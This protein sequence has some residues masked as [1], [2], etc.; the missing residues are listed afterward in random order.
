ML[1]YIDDCLLT[2]NREIEYK[3]LEAPLADKVIVEVKEIPCYRTEIEVLRPNSGL[4]EERLL[5][6]GTE[7][8]LEFTRSSPPA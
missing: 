3:P 7:F 4:C 1:E 6:E 8:P 2:G 5:G